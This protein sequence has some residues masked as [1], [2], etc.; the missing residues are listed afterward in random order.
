MMMWSGRPLEM[1]LE[2][3]RYTLAP[4]LAATTPSAPPAPFP[5]IV[6]TPPSAS[7]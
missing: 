4:L 2:M 3:G 6:S 7:T 5:T 1:A